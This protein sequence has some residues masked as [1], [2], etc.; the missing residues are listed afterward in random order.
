MKPLDLVDVARS[1]V[2]F[3]QRRPTDAYL[4][5]AVSSLYYALFHCLTSSC[6][7]TLVGKTGNIRQSEAWQKTY[8]SLEHGLAKQACGNL[9][10][11]FSQPIVNF[12]ELFKSLQELRHDADYRPNLN[13]RLSKSEVLT[14]IL[15]V[16]AVIVAF[17]A[18]TL[19]ERRAFSVH[20]LFKHRR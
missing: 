4:R 20:V 11:Q 17:E 14:S 18:C 12:A 6:A 15:A 7:D 2:N 10:G 19:I 13:P 1:L 16:E 3:N 5:R 9:G 8:R